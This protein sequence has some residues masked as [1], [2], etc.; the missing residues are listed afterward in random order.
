[1]KPSIILRACLRYGGARGFQNA[2]E[3]QADYSLSMDLH[4]TGK[5]N[6]INSEGG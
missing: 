1:M 5:P 2:H 4:V 3:M 6:S